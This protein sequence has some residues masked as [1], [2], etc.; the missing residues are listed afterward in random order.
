MLT[1]PY[2][3]IDLPFLAASAATRETA[4]QFICRASQKNAGQAPPLK[5]DSFVLYC[6]M[7]K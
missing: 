5:G 3:R 4:K 6:Q 7:K 2:D 1:H